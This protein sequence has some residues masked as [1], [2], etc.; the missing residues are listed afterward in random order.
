MK[1]CLQVNGRE[2]CFSEEELKTKLERLAELE[3]L[4]ANQGIAKTPTEGKVFP[5]NPM[6]INQVL[7]VKKEVENSKN[8]QGKLFWRHLLK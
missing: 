6:G 2:E 3:T 5:V 4:F 7:S 1:I 8:G